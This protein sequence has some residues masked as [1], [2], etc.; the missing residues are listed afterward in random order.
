[1]EATKPEVEDTKV[2]QKV[3]EDTK[4]TEEG[5]A[6]E[7]GTTGEEEKMETDKTEEEGQSISSHVNQ[8]FAESLT[9]MGYTKAVAEKSLFLTQNAS[10]EAAIGWIEQHQDDADFLEELRIVGQT[11][12]QKVSNLTPEEAKQKAKELQDE[13]RRRRIQ[14]DKELELERERERVRSGK[15][16]S[17]AKR[18]LEEAEKERGIQERL[19]EKREAEA[20]KKKMLELLQRDKEER[21]G[22]KFTAGGGAAKEEKTPE[23]KLAHAIKTVKTL[24]TSFRHP[25]VAKTCFTTLRAYCNNVL[26]DVNDPKYRKIRLANNAYQERVAKVTGGN[27]FLKAVGFK[28][29]A[30]FFELESVDEALVRKAVDSLEAELKNMF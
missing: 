11:E 12:Q 14:K 18:L 15:E 30:E 4:T 10:I 9:A 27:L 16:M 26:K 28:E 24:Y 6:T 7:E 29:G 13:V 22:K 21:F 3:E 5:K 1:M 19:R 25:G 17:K 8:T 20:E 2:D 23:E